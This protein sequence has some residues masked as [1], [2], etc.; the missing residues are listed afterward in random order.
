MA[1]PD[2][3]GCGETLTDTPVRMVHEHYGGSESLPGLE[4]IVVC[5]ASLI[6]GQ[7]NLELLPLV[8]SCGF[9]HFALSQH[10]VFGY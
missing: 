5:F 10:G 7:A 3:C 4:G 6:V 9:Q 8:V 1:Q 2:C